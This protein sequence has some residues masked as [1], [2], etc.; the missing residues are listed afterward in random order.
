M[1]AG[2]GL[3]VIQTIHL[4]RGLSSVKVNQKNHLSLGKK[5]PIALFILIPKHVIP[6]EYRTLI[7]VCN[8]SSITCSNDACADNSSK[9]IY[10]ISQSGYIDGC[11][12]MS[13]LRSCGTYYDNK[14]FDIPPT[15]V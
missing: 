7:Y 11:R 12:D 4:Q 10:S 5:I 9:C 1:E 3:L 13:H 8:G 6:T 2:I 15:I 14:R